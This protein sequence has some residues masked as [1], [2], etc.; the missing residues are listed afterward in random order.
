M[1]FFIK[2]RENVRNGEEAGDNF[3]KCPFGA[4]FAVVE[5]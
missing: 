2:C 4:L 3:Q 1:G 5:Q